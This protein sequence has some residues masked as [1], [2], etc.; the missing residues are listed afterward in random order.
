[1]RELNVRKKKIKKGEVSHP[2]EK[3]K[4]TDLTAQ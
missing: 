4:S 3:K 2:Q 1:M